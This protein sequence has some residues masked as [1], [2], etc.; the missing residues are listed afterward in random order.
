MKRMYAAIAVVLAVL[1]SAAVL[2]AQTD[3]AEGDGML[4]D[5][6]NGVT[7][8]TAA[9]GTDAVDMAEQFA[10]SQGLEFEKDGSRIVRIGEMAEHSVGTQVCGWHLYKWSGTAWTPSTDTSRSSGSI[11][12]GFYPEGTIPV[13]TP[14]YRA[15]W[16]QF[17]GDSSN[18]GVSDSYGTE[19]AVTPVEW[20]KTY[21]TGYV[22]SSLIVAGDL[23][24]HTTYGETTASGSRSHAQLYCLNRLTADMVWIFDLTTGGGKYPEVK[25]NGYNI[26]SP[27][28]IGDMIAINSATSHSMDG[29]TVMDLYL[30]DR[31]TGE[32]IDTEEILHAPPLNDRGMPVWKGRT[33]VNGGTSPVY[34][35]GALYFGT[36]DG[37]IL[38]YSVSHEGLGLLWEY[39]PPSDT[40]GDKYVGS[41]GSFYYYS[42]TIVDIDGVRMLFIGNYEGYIIALNASTGESIWEKQ[43][44]ALYEKNKG[45][46]G[47][48]GAVDLIT[49]IGDNR[50]IVNCTDGAM[51]PTMGHIVCIDAKTGGGSGGS[52]CYWRIDGVTQ[53]TVPVGDGDFIIYAKKASSPSVDTDPAIKD[54][55][56]YRLD[57]DGNTKWYVTSNYIWSRMTVA[58]GLLYYSEYSAG[59]YD[60]GGHVV[61]KRI[62][63]G[64]TVWSAK[65]EPYSKTSYSMAAPTVIEGKIYAANDYGAV[66]CISEIEGKKWDGGGEIILPGGFWHW[67]WALL[68]ALAVAAVIVLVRYY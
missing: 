18:S 35:S 19:K 37:R 65:L 2:S 11:A 68:I 66:Y 40:S 52:D 5:M 26:T 55:G 36:S 4:I 60:D 14:E 15:A 51:S 58:E 31:F 7:Y 21:R 62:T 16:T 24:Y 33:F 41:R 49:Y 53:G 46:P 63:D 34:D 13:E 43:Y 48:P 45:V 38:A 6:G 17:R 23:M 42:P 28:I 27:V 56:L 39:V 44:I 3:A 9:S 50:L 8:W 57:K 1:V 47:T 10:K 67:S 32:V 22:D 30:L 12:W 25:D 54:D 20:Y 61:A 59:F 29:K 64:S